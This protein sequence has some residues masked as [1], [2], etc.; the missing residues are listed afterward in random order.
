M[1]RYHCLCHQ[2]FHRHDHHRHHHRHHHLQT[3]G[4]VDDTVN[5]GFCAAV[6]RFGQIWFLKWVRC[7]WYAAAGTE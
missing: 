1:P 3:G 4:S 7:L 5:T 2:G 6:K